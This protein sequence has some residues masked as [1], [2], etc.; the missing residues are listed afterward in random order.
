VPYAEISSF[1]EFRIGI[2]LFL[3]CEVR[4]RDDRLRVDDEISVIREILSFM[5]DKN[6]ESFASEGREKWGV[7]TIRS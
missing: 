3:W 7:C 4:L 1:R 2:Y 5:S 6:L